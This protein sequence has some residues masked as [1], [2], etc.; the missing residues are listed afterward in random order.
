MLNKF[1]EFTDIFKQLNGMCNDI[2][3]YLPIETDIV[4]L[5]NTGIIDESIDSSN[6]SY[7]FFIGRYHKD[8]TRNYS[9]ME[10]Y[11][12]MAI[13]EGDSN[14]MN[15]LGYYHQN[16]TKNYSEMEKYY[17]MAIEKGSKHTINILKKYYDNIEPDIV[18]KIQYTN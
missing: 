11:Y 1:N 4:K 15:N 9:E 16:I 17:L 7:L 12:L 6:S 14:A 3:K 2:N 18:K 5:F 10:K 8:I 13:E